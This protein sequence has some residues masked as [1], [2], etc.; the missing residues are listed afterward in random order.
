MMMRVVT[1]VRC[2]LCL[3]LVDFQLGPVHLWLGG[4]APCLPCVQLRVAF[5]LVRNNRECWV[6]Y[7]VE[8]DNLVDWWI[9]VDYCLMRGLNA[10]VRLNSVK[11]KLDCGSRD[12]LSKDAYLCFE[13]GLL[14][15]ALRRICQ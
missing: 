5:L 3:R 15:V 2:R 6:D 10:M 1:V 12:L 7:F 11:W 4:G 13:R 9:C 8:V 14:T